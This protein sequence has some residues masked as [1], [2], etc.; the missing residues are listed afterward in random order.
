MGDPRD[1]L[2]AVN[3]PIV[4][5]EHCQAQFNELKWNITEQMICA[6]YKSE[7]KGFCLLD[8]GGALVQFTTG[9]PTLVGVASFGLC[10]V[11]DFSDVF[12]NVASVRS[13]IKTVTGA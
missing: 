8:N 12:S 10:G 2:H 7:E 3:I 13:W 4:S 6:G 9:N 5:R 11:H 1:Q